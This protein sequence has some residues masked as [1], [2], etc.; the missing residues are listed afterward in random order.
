MNQKVFRDIA[1]Y[2]GDAAGIFLYI[3]A[4][5]TGAFCFHLLWRATSADQQT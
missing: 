4:S 5:V 1:E 3:L 2:T